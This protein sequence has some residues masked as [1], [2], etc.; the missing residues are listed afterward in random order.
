LIGTLALPGR[1]IFTPLGAWVPR[2]FVAGGIFAVQVLGILC[3]C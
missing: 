1:L 3:W 2:R